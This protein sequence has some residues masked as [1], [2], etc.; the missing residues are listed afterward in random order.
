MPLEPVRQT[1]AGM[2]MLSAAPASPAGLWLVTG[3][4]QLP[5]TRRDQRRLLEAVKIVCL[6]QDLYVWQQELTLFLGK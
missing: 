5:T 3:I 2:K 6:E 1:Q 4:L